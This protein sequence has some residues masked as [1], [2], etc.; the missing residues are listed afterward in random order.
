[1]VAPSSNTPSRG[2]LSSAS[3]SRRR[4]WLARAMASVA[5]VA[6]LG[7]AS[8]AIPAVAADSSAASN[9][10]SIDFDALG[11]L[12]V[13][14]NF[15]GLEIFNASIEV[16]Q[17]PVANGS[18]IV[19]RA[20]NGTLT[21]IGSTNP[22]ASINAVTTGGSGR[23]SASLVYIGGNFTDIAGT[24]AANI[25]AYDPT[26]RTWDNLAGGLN[27][28][29]HALYYA[30]EH[31][32]LIAGGSFTRPVDAG[33]QADAYQGSVALW[34]ED[35]RQWQPLNFGGLNGTVYSISGGFDPN[36]IRF[37]GN[38]LALYGSGK[39]ATSDTMSS[40]SSLSRVLQPYSLAMAQLT[41]GPPSQSPD[42]N[43]PLQILCPQGTD[44]PGNT[45][46]FAAGSQGLLTVETFR[47]L[48]I[49]AIRLGNTR[50]GGRGLRGFSVVSLPDNQ[51]LELVYKNPATGAN[52][53]CSDDC[54][55]SHREGLVYQDFLISP[56]QGGSK[57]LTGIQLRV[58]SF[59]GE[60]AGLHILELLSDGAWT[61]ANNALNRGRCSSPVEGVN[62]T[63]SI[64]SHNGNWD[65]TSVTRS[66]GPQQP[67]LEFTDSYANLDTDVQNNV[68]VVFNVDIPVDG[69]YTGYMSIPGC[70]SDGSCPRRTLALATVYPTPDRSVSFQTYVNQTV[71]QD[72]TV[73]IFDG[74]IIGT[75]AA[76]IEGASTFLPQVVLS[77]APNATGPAGQ[78]EFTIVA[79]KVAFQLRNS[80]QT[81]PMTGPG[82]A[83]GLFEFDV[84]NSSATLP[85]V[86][87]TTLTRS[88]Q[89][90]GSLPLLGGANL[91][92]NDT[93]ALSSAFSS[94]VASLSE[95]NNGAARTNR[96]K[97]RQLAESETSTSSSA[98]A[99]TTAAG[100]GPTQPAGLGNTTQYENFAIQLFLPSYQNTT[101]TSLDHFATNLF[102]AGVNG[103]F[104][105]NS[106][107]LGQPS[108]V[109]FAVADVNNFT[110]V[111]G[112]FSSTAPLSTP[113]GF[114]NLIGFNASSGGSNFTRLAGAGLNGPVHALVGD[115]NILYVGGNFTALA[116]S[117]NTS[118]PYFGKYDVAANSWVSTGSALDGPVT[119]LTLLPN[120]SLLLTGA[121]TA[122]G[123]TLSNGGYALYNTSSG[124][125][126][127]DEGLVSGTVN[128][129]A[130][131]VDD[132]TGRNQTT[133][134]LV[135]P[136]TAVSDVAVPGA[137][138]IEPADVNG[139]FPS[140]DALN[141]AF[142][143][144][145]PAAQTTAP[146][147]QGT[148]LSNGTIALGN[149]T[150]VAP[151][152]TIIYQ[153][154]R[155]K[156]GTSKTA[157][158]L[159]GSPNVVQRLANKVVRR[160][161][162]DMVNRAAS[163]AEGERDL[164]TFQRRASLIEPEIL[165][166]PNGT[167]EIYT[168]AFWA[169]ADGSYLQIIG[170]QF[171]T[172]GNVVNL[173][174]YDP[175]TKTLNAFPALPANL[176]NF[177]AVRALLVVGNQVFVGGDG[178]IA[179]YDFVKAAWDNTTTPLTS[180]SQ[181]PLTVRTIVHRPDTSEIYV[182]GQFDNAGSLP[183]SS[184]CM[185][186]NSQLRWNSLGT[187]LDGD[188]AVLDFAG[189]KAVTLIAAGSLEV[190]GTSTPLASYD[191]TQDTWVALGSVGG[192][193]DQA[194]GAATAMS[195]DN[196]QLNSI[197]VGGRSQDGSTA[198]L[199]KWDGAKYI[200]LGSSEIQPATGIQQL[201]FVPILK[202]HDG[203][204]ILENNRL[205]VV[206]GVLELTNF[207][208]VSSA[209]FDG[210]NWQPF[211]LGAGSDGTNGI[212]R[213]V[214]RATEVL[215]FSNL[216]RLAVGIVILI[217]IAIGLGLVFLLTLLG[218]LW[219]MARRNKNKGVDAPLSAQDDMPGDGEYPGRPSSLLATLNAATENVMGAS[220]AGSGGH[221]SQLAGAPGSGG[222]GSGYGPGVAGV[223]AG[224]AAAAAAAAAAGG[225]AAATSSGHGRADSGPLNTIEN[226]DE[227]GG[228]STAYHSEGAQTGRSGASQYFTDDENAGGAAL[229]AGAA[230][231]GAAAAAAAAAAGAG[232]AG[233]EGIPARA[234][235]SFE[236]THESELSMHAGD[237][238]TILDDLDEHW[239]LARDANGREGVVPSTYVL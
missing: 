228:P 216:R 81:T 146:N 93:A 170:G 86:V 227:T 185:W 80:N 105:F 181:A 108:Q 50:V 201:T 17:T 63:R 103:G 121:F 66:L 225:A 221:G 55:L 13:V 34:N 151:N 178:G 68:N 158:G 74:Q 106:T 110:F 155:P 127:E 53:T 169:R 176:A 135:G 133:T 47:V 23:G 231:A 161:V 131:A 179:S 199:A 64:T 211:L 45:Y 198:Y 114:A 83:F 43:N 75:Q 107:E 102:D 156:K 202:A 100:A 165:M 232:G 6:V 28:T 213:A 54:I 220:A 143:K 52:V 117:S 136:I 115:G 190:G 149:G 112:N 10:P 137:A 224:A 33:N 182:G 44:G 205:L 32:T 184:V 51:V 189:P 186:D 27:G 56:A 191:T 61:W 73:Q 153:P 87:N 222:H 19:A 193:T 58:N 164:H 166:S 208:N 15:V 230:G 124:S 40:P 78:T 163:T 218:L 85:T 90:P 42:Y 120:S 196:L 21:T 132:S 175:V 118:M 67:I 38:F 60:G 141:F 139:G 226:S 144:E 233:A 113:S 11:A 82:F 104:A 20:P 188:I 206:S 173:G 239:W 95:A 209:F 183:C 91:T 122:A 3:G 36:F 57:V 29:V 18:S 24:N 72:S 37:T 123:S 129:A 5:A 4:T 160:A 130:I 212:V 162:E 194:P 167:N 203:N 41:G 192:G 142:Q 145:A 84:F 152:G 89:I 128:A 148:V 219:A 147:L 154:A 180:D 168:S 195:V 22:N 235:Y 39:N 223:G 238:I 25:A 236:A 98:T 171:V 94:L 1:M 138:K 97:A 88:V 77:I 76:A 172:S 200:N 157:R 229:G 140:I 174:A 92:G 7:L 214:V 79:D 187:S 2:A 70:L 116:D 35:N 49:A 210:A 119:S 14:G 101:Q 48:Q 9:F 197:F 71:E 26:A 204:G 126:I 150:L 96:P 99:S 30:A 8:S 237:Q 177:T 134:Y 59:Y 234:R 46:L 159:A 65:F 31:K 12:G 217:S 111:G 69:N 16:Q 125:W 109:I 215:K 62:G 207:G